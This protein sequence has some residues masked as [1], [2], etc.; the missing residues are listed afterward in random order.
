MKKVSVA[1]GVMF[2]CSIGIIICCLSTYLYVIRYVMP[3]TDDFAISNEIKEGLLIE[4]SYLQ[5]SLKLTIEKYLTWQG[6]FVS[7][8]LAYFSAPFVRMGA[9]GIRIFCGLTILMF[10][11]GLWAFVHSVMKYLIRVERL[12]SIVFVFSLILYLVTNVRNPMEVFYWYVGICVYTVPLICTLLGIHCMIKYIYEERIQSYIGVIIFGMLACGGVLQCSAIICFVYLLVGIWSFFKKHEIQK[13]IWLAFGFCFFGALANSLAPGNFIRHSVI[14]TTGLPVFSAI[15]YSLQNVLI[16]SRR[17]LKETD[18]PCLAVIIFGVGFWIKDKSYNMVKFR[19]ILLLFLSTFLGLL[20]SC[21]PVALGYSSAFMEPRGYFILDMFIISGLV[22]GIWVLG[23]IMCQW[24]TKNAYS[25]WN[26]NKIFGGAIILLFI[27]FNIVN[28]IREIERPIVN[29][30]KDEKF[31]YLERF[32]IMWEDILYQ[33]EN[34]EEKNVVVKSKRIPSPQILKNPDLS[35]D[36]SYWVNKIVAQYY[37][38]ESV[39]IEWID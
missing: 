16:E 30:I 27:I 29:S 31:G 23:N 19:Y 37:D 39:T 2:C 26:Y 22:L 9:N 5:V 20:A 33:I 38:K 11:G 15:G 12:T 28:P 4:D 32:S 17:L 25:R 8:F 14:D 13:K 7:T 35:S 1:E 3:A 21:Y 18:L 10:M 6:T 24:M 36:S 34:A